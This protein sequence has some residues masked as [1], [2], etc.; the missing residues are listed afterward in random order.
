MHNSE[1]SKEGEKLHKDDQ[2]TSPKRG[3]SLSI[4]TPSPGTIKRK[5]PGPAGIL[6]DETQS[7]SDIDFS[8]QQTCLMFEE[9]PWKDMSKDFKI[10]NTLYLFDKFNIAWIKKEALANHFV[11]EKVPFLVAVLCS[12]EISEG[13]KQKLVNITLKDL[14][15][16]IQGTIHYSL[17]KTFEK[18]LTLGSVLVIIQ[19]G[20]LSCT[21]DKCDNHHITITSKNLSAI[22]GPR[23]KSIISTIEP[24]HLLRN[25]YT[26]KKESDNLP[27]NEKLNTTKSVETVRNKCYTQIS[28]RPL[29]LFSNEKVLDKCNVM[30]KSS[31]YIFPTVKN[32]ISRQNAI[33][34]I[35]SSKIELHSNQS[36]TTEYKISQRVSNYKSNDNINCSQGNKIQNDEHKEAY[37][38]LLEGIDMKT[39][40]DEF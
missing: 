39:F 1:M 10:S 5:F 31:N 20:V 34:N 27:H 40:F 22:Y 4:D 35:P 37:K 30:K 6:P 38:A 32:N 17:Y 8:S 3:I 29:L 23:E 36:T 25:Y 33:D 28:Q 7:N 26:K 11:N 19:F 9:G 18:L 12:L 14:T 15:G 16:S 13:Q 21:C 2:I 24:E